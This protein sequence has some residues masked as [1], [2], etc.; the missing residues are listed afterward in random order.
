MRSLIKTLT[1]TKDKKHYLV[2]F[3]APNKHHNGPFPIDFVRR[4]FT[5]TGKALT[6]R[7][8]HLISYADMLSVDI[9]EEP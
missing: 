9:S 1:L 7:K 6:Q 5:L 3:H 8:D 2:F 4:E